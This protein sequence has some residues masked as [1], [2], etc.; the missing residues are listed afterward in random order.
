MAPV[1]KAIERAAAP[2]RAGVS[3][4]SVTGGAWASPKAIRAAYPDAAPRRWP[5]MMLRGRA[6]G[7]CDRLNT[8]KAVGPSDGTTSG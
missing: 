1:V 7:V 2:I 4:P 3:P 8:R 6:A 5:R